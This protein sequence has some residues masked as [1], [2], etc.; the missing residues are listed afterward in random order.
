MPKEYAEEHAD[1]W[2]SPWKRLLNARLYKD[3]GWQ[4]PRNT[5][6]TQ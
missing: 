6:V 3:Q 4:V 5:T 1:I 2:N